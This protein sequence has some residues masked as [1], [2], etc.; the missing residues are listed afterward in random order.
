LVNS[1][2]DGDYD[3]SKTP[4]PGFSYCILFY[5]VVFL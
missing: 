5:T 2:P 3:G 4:F 1:T